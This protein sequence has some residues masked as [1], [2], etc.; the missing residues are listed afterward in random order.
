MT[1]YQVLIQKSDGSFGQD[2]VNCD[3]SQNSIVTNRQCT[4][5]MTTLMQSPFGLSQGSNVIAKITATNIVGTSI[6]SNVNGAPYV[7]LSTIPNTPSTGPV[8]SDYSESYITI[9][10][11]GI[12]A[13]NT[14]GSPITSY[15]LYWD[16]G[17]S[18]LYFTPLVGVNTLNMIQTFTATGLTSGQSY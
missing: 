2:T 9:L 3:G 16:N 15:A 18:G 13:G 6:A 8:I 11:P 12:T 7:T 14:G 4:I 1:S 5:P 17:L 10:M